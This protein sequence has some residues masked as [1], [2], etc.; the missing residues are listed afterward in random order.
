MD[1]DLKAY[2][3]E[4]FHNKSEFDLSILVREDDWNLAN[5]IKLIIKGKNPSNENEIEV[6]CDHPGKKVKKKFFVKYL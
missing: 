5:Q 1:F 2:F 6:F 4:I 3:K